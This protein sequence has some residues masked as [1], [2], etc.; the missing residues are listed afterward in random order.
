LSAAE[1][2]LEFVERVGYGRWNAWALPHVKGSCA[3][4]RIGESPKYAGASIF[5]DLIS[6]DESRTEL[7]PVT[8]EYIEVGYGIFTM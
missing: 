4:L 3:I 5:Q 6:P 1:K 7:S 8:F 2:G